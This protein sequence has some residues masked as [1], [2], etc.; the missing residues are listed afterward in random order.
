MVIVKVHTVTSRQAIV[1]MTSMED[2]L[3]VKVAGP[4]CQRDNCRSDARKCGYYQQRLQAELIPA[5]FRLLTHVR[6][7]RLYF[8]C[9]GLR[10]FG[11]GAEELGSL[12]RALA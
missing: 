10:G 4:H 5:A 2:G 12:R 11:A 6:L 9:H 7:R 8:I 1:K 3:V